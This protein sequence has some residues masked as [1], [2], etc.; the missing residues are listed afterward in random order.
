M[1]PDLR[2]GQIANRAGYDSLPAFSLAFKSQLG[3]P[4]AAWRAERRA[5]NNQALRL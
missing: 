2:L 3:L 4:P 5:A 1:S